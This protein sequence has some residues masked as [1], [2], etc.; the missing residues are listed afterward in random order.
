MGKSLITKAFEE[1]KEKIDKKKVERSV[2]AQVEE[3]ER[4]M[5]ADLLAEYRK[6]AAAKL[7][8]EKGEIEA[9]DK[10]REHAEKYFEQG[11][12]IPK[13]LADDIRK[14]FIF[15]TMQDNDTM[16]IY[17]E[18]LYRDGDEGIVKKAIGERLQELLTIHYANE[19]LFSIKS[20]TYTKREDP[21]KNLINLRNG[22]FNLETRKLEAHNPDIFTIT[23]LPVVY[24]PKA[25]CP[26][27]RKFIRE[28]VNPEDVPAIQELVGYT[29]YPALPFQIA[30]LLLGDR[31]AGKSTLLNVVAS[32]LGGENVSDLS[33]QDLSYKRFLLAELYGKL[34]NIF[35][36]L[37]D[38]AMKHTGIFKM[39]TGG[40]R[41][42]GER[43]HKNP[44]YFTNYAKLIFSC[45]KIPETHDFGDA[46]FRRW[47]IIEFP[48]CFERKAQD[49]E[50]LGKIT[51]EKEMSGLFNWSLEGLYR[52]L[53][54]GDFSNSP[55]IQETRDIYLQESSSMVK[56]LE[57]TT[58]TNPESCVSKA[59]LYKEF[60]LFCKREK[61]APLTTTGFSIKF[62]MMRPMVS[63]ARLGAKGSRVL[64]WMGIGLKR[65]GAEQKCL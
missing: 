7:A 15:K 53:N 8:K 63:T 56:F 14:D 20:L 4:E 32:L 51:T 12:F 19:T 45:N 36:D 21:P 50:L 57:E 55:T 22:M 17:D 64:S 41:I 61:I 46:Y 47:R 44:F 37:S 1:E 2:E 52:L 65:E 43:K 34:A 30:F 26:K 6:K 62:K 11:K 60:V 23:Q 31:C 58:E 33:L 59:D 24:N 25:K 42:M 18:G 35:A 5:R 9:V 10:T 27:I 39:L 28:V 16:Y 48:N 3:E 49:K 54:R 13:L 29:L 40:D 38:Q